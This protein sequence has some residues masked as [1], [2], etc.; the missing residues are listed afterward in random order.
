MPKSAK[1]KKGKKGKSRSPSPPPKPVVTEKPEEPL[2]VGIDTQKLTKGESNLLDSNQVPGADINDGINKV[3]LFLPDDASSIDEPEEEGQV[4]APVMTADHVAN[5][6]SDIGISASGEAFVFL[7]VNLT[8]YAC[9]DISILKGYHHLQ[10]VNLSHN[11]LTD[12]SS[13]STMNCLIELDASHNRLPALLDFTAPFGLRYANF[14]H[15][16][17]DELPD[18][19][20]YTHLLSLDCSFNRISSIQGLSCCKSLKNLCLSDNNIKEIDGLDNLNLRSIDLSRNSLTEINGL[21]SVKRLQS[22]NL[23][24]NKISSLK[25]FDSDNHTILDSINFEDNYV[26]ALNELKN[27]QAIKSLRCLNFVNNPM[28]EVEEYRKSVIFSMQQLTEL[29]RQPIAVGEKVEA[30]NLFDPP[31]EVQAALDHITHTVYRFLQP[32]KIYESTLPNIEM[33]Y[34][35]LVLCGPQASGKREL[36]H[37]L[38]QD[39]PDYFGFGVSHTT[40]APRPGEEDGKDYHFVSPDEFQGLVRQGCFVQTFKYAGALY[41]LALESIENVAKEGLACV[42]HME[43]NGVRTLKN[44]YFE[45]RYVLVTPVKDSEHRARMQSRGYYSDAQIK[46]VIGKQNDMYKEVDQVHPGFFDMVINSDKLT[47]AYDRLRQLV[48]DYLG[49]TDMVSSEGD[50]GG[51][52]QRLASMENKDEGA[53]GAVPVTSHHAMSANIMRR[54]WSRPSFHGDSSINGNDTASARKRTLDSRKTPVEEASFRR[55]QIAAQEALEGYS[56]GAVYDDLFRI[57]IVPMTA[58]A[59]MEG[60]PMA[61]ATAMYKDPAFGGA[62]YQEIPTEAAGKINEQMM[63]PST[64]IMRKSGGSTPDSSKVSRPLSSGLSGLSSAQGFSEVEIDHVYKMKAVDDKVPNAV[65]EKPLDLN[66]LSDALESLKGSL[67]D[68]SRATTPLGPRQNGID[69][70]IEGSNAKPVLPPIPTGLN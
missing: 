62:V 21:S 8:G 36:A 66:A 12:L 26:T 51:A 50:P 22:I 6:L 18:L 58:P 56:P 48:M 55:R 65:D 54:T 64:G 9:H 44:T 1:G 69:Q 15:N 37:K 60:S 10:K 46:Q 42:V 19:S 16:E 7:S 32:S 14:S 57:P 34:P 23:S 38:A 4:Q 33:P 68:S 25:G 39:F 43:I 11:D 41:G 20:R 45:P 70:W 40:R 30:V 5:C 24:G 27:I 47:D 59:V 35:M 28:A 63:G 31:A 49:T 3:D 61:Q 17:I 29:D 52:L 2:G 67:K 13:L 53:G